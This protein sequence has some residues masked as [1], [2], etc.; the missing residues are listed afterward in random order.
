LPSQYTRFQLRGIVKSLLSVTWLSAKA[1]IQQVAG[2]GENHHA[3]VGIAS[4]VE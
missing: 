3:G 4:D 2:A 1:A